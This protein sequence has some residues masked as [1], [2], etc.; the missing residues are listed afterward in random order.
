[1]KRGAL[2]SS[3]A[4]GNG[5]APV[6]RTVW[7]ICEEIDLAAAPGSWQ[8]SIH[9]AGTSMGLDLYL[10]GYQFHSHGPCRSPVVDHARTRTG[11]NPNVFVAVG[12]SRR[13][14]QRIRRHP[15]AET[16]L[17]QHIS[18]GASQGHSYCTGKSDFADT[19]SRVFDCR[20]GRGQP[21]SRSYAARTSRSD[22]GSRR[23]RVRCCFWSV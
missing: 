15:I 17:V 18:S 16:Y 6:H 20:G 1:M 21:G 8:D 2:P 11:A 19:G 3:L 9:L 14:R 13:L 12:D 5:S 10:P 4:G 7:D 23:R 22:A